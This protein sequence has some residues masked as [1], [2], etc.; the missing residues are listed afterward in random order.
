MLMFI[1]EVCHG[2][3]ISVHLML[4]QLSNMLY[5]ILCMLRLLALVV[6][7]IS[8][9]MILIIIQLPGMHVALTPCHKCHVLQGQLS[10]AMIS[11][12]EVYGH[13]YASSH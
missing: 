6:L 13:G 8:H 12:R 9:S 7:L 3:Y 2:I 1:G 5:F 4:L 10:Q 11:G